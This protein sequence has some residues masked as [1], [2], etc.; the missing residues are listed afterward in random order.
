MDLDTVA[1]IHGALDAGRDLD[2]KAQVSIEK[3]KGF[4]EKGWNRTR[5]WF[6]VVANA[7][8]APLGLAVGYCKVGNVLRNGQCIAGSLSATLAAG[9][10]IARIADNAMNLARSEYGHLSDAHAQKH[11]N[12]FCA[13][14]VQEMTT[15]FKAGE[16]T[17]GAHC[18]GKVP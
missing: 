17:R 9:V 13:G 18:K 3:A 15:E 1:S 7:V 4:M 6:I 12:A 16:R 11:A 14:F 2:A 8:C 10:I 5:D